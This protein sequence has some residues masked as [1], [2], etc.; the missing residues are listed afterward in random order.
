[1]KASSLNLRHLR[2]LKAVHHTGSITRAAD[3]VFLSQPAITQGIA[4]LEIAFRAKLFVR[5][6][7]GM[8]P[9]PAGEAVA[10]R[11][12]R[13]LAILADGCRQAAQRAK[14]RRDGAFDLSV[15]AN[16]LRALD[17]MARHGSFSGA[18]RDLQ[19]AQPSLHRVARDLEHLAGFPLYEK[20]SAGIALT[21]GAKILNRAAK[22]TFAELRQAIDEVRGHG[23]RL[24]TDLI[25]GSLPLPR[26]Q[27]LPSAIARLAADAPDTVIRVIDGPYADLLEGLR[28]GDLDM[29]VGA[30]RA[31]APD[32][33]DQIPLFTDRLGIYCGPSHPLAGKSDLRLSDLCGF[34]WVVPRHPTPTRAIFDAVCE[35]AG[36]SAEVAVVETSSMI[37][38]RGLLSVSDRLTMLSQH[39]AATEMHAGHLYLLDLRF[40]DLGRPIGISVRQDWSPTPTQTLFISHLKDTAR[41]YEAAVGSV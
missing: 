14:A 22:L 6:R 28:E 32:E 1:M 36:L 33:V 10:R 27:L 9:T 41:A 23:A 3:M 4:K 19:V 21:P 31:P 12:E 29:I 5:G 34:G 20:T 2:A 11:V 39:Q 35:T 15:T 17:A 16:Q 37:L 8:T 25:V 13:A 24:A 40:E 38:V 7:S 18:A 26:A 30:L